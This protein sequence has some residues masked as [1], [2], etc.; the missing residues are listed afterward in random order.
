[1]VCA[2]VTQ[3][4]VYLLYPRVRSLFRWLVSAMDPYA[5]IG[6]IESHEKWLAEASKG[7]RADLALQDLRG[8]DFRGCSLRSAKLVGA[9]L[10][11]CDASFSLGDAGAGSR[12]PGAGLRLPCECIFIQSIIARSS[13][14]IKSASFPSEVAFMAT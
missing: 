7:K 10:E 1:M 3:S 5:L 11:A 4:F 8:F 14:L 2:K 6:I 13:S 12:I 9:V